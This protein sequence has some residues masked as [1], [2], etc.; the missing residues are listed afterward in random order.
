MGNGFTFAN[1]S[2]GE[3]EERTHAAVDLWN[4]EALRRRFI[5]K[6]MNIDLSWKSSAEQYLQMYAPLF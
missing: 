2:A 3:L 5:E 1:Y 4:D 6:I